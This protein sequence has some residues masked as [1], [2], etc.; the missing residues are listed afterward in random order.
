MAKSLQD[1]KAGNKILAGQLAAG[2]PPLTRLALAY[3]PGGVRPA[4]T[5][6]FALDAR[7]AGIVRG[8]REPALAQLRLAWW[9]ERLAAGAGGGAGQDPLLALLAAWPGESA[10]LAGLADGW[11][12]MTGAAPLQGSAF[13]GLAE[14]RAGALAALAEDDVSA[15]AARRMARNWALLDLAMHLS[16]PRER[17]A[18]L[19]LAR[20]QDWRWQKLP[21]GLRPLAVL[22]GLAARTIQGENPDMG[23]GPLALLCAMR[24][25]LFGR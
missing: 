6:I 12:E 17:D 19:K 1:M 13:I 4:L 11:E 3:A 10:A 8:S 16:D 24:I 18:A 20:E 5:L 25:G 7:M 9:R 15:S 2:L 23:S 14:A 22:H 21:R